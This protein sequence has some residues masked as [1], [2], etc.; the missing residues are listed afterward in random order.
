MN[1]QRKIDSEK[2]EEFDIQK[3]V[4]RLIDHWKLFIF[5]FLIFIILG[6]LF[7]FLVTPSY[8]ISSQILVEDDQN[9]NSAL[10]FMGNSSSSQMLGS[11]LGIKSNVYN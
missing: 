2:N 8:Q 3:L 11:L 6:V 1:E 4:S 9:S 7:I 5:S 10:S